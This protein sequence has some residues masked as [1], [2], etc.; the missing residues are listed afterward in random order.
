M[1]ASFW[2][3][4]GE[5]GKALDETLRNFGTV[6]SRPRVNFP[7][8]ST[9][10]LSWS[11]M[12]EDLTGTGA[13]IPDLNQ[14]VTLWRDG[15][16]FFQGQVTGVE[17]DNHNVNV[18]V[19]DAWWQAEN[20]PLSSLQTA[21]TTTKERFTYVFPTQSLST[22]ITSLVTRTIAL[23]V[24]WQLGTVATT[25]SHPRI[26]LNQSSCGLAIA[27]LVRLCPDMQAWLDHSTTPPTLNFT[28]RLSGL[29]TGSAAAITLDARTCDF[30]AAPRTELKVEQVTIPYASRATNGTRQHSEQIAG[31]GSRV[32]MVVVSGEELDTF[33]PNDQFDSVQIRTV[34]LNDPAGLLAFAQTADPFLASLVQTYGANWFQ[35][36]TVSTGFYFGYLDVAT[37]VVSW[38]EGSSSSP[39]VKTR[40]TNVPGQ[41]DSAG[42][43]LPQASWY[44][45]RSGDRIPDWITGN[46]VNVKDGKLS[47]DIVV[48]HNFSLS[49]TATAGPA[50]ESFFDKCYF[51]RLGYW[52]TSG[53]QKQSIGVYQVEVPVSFVSTQ[54]NSATTV[55]RAADY[56]FISPPAG[57]AAGLLAAQNWVP[58]EGQIR[59]AEQEAGGQRYAGRLI[60]LSNA[61]T[62]LAT[63]GALIR[64]EELD[65]DTG[66]TTLDLGAAPRL[67]FQNVVDRVRRTSQDNIVYL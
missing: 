52:N 53:S 54:Y 24:P 33:L 49:A 35:D 20:I 56:D 10:S 63:M 14:Q 9:G 6:G 3:L 44:A 29:V 60:H 2:Q 64:R 47:F 31:S 16:K 58:Y 22:S 42:V 26:S 18:T 66:T 62:P 39:T 34:R 7:S 15:A 8:L 57:F 23:G 13:I 28:R 65:I 38:G 51:K 48:T 55:Y 32:Q 43:A 21:G 59:F 1:S 67:S 61:R 25:Y 50:M 37:G 27:E 41:V 46:G 45:V 30:R 4:Q 12:L 19:S 36:F 11:K 5:T 40:A 17:Q